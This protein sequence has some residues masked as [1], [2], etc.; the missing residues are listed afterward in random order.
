MSVKLRWKKYPSGRSTAYLDIYTKGQNRKYV[1]TDIHL[2][3][4]EK[5]EAKKQKIQKAD[6]Y[7][8]KYETSLLN[9]MVGIISDAK[10]NKCFLSYYQEF[11]DHY[12]KPG[13]R[14][15]KGAFGKFK[16]FYKGYSSSKKLPFKNLDHRLFEGF[17]EY[18]F[19]SKSK[20]N[21]ET[22]YDYFKRVKAI[23]NR[24]YKEG[25][26]QKNIS[27]NVIVKKPK[28]R[29]KKQI[30]TEEEIKLLASKPCS[31]NEV[32]RAFLFS[33]FTGLGE[34]EIRNLKWTNIQNG[35]LIIDRAKSNEPINNKLPESALK[36]LQEQGKSEE[37]I[38][39]LPSNTTVKKQIENWVKSAEIDKKITFY[40]GRHS[41][42]VMLLMNG[43]NLKTVADSLGH[44]DT[45][46]TIKYLNY[47]DALKDKAMDSLVKIDI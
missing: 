32:K 41:F 3:K 24:A 27:D 18:L 31:N 21:G 38:F 11:L 40:C 23:I 44:S 36:L 10:L 46:H 4:S 8:A 5:G 22:P 34:Q 30:L 28:S 45:S 35:R 12:D 13:K 26:L 6:L 2:E 20:L 16:S 9:E 7:R 15:Y 29:I 39:E 33:C 37:H 19:S 25:Y 17:K 1:F 14:K 42:A 43:A 47:V